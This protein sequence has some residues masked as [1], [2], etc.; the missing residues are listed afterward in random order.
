MNVIGRFLVIIFVIF[1]PHTKCGSK[2]NFFFEYSNIFKPLN[3]LNVSAGPGI[4]PYIQKSMNGFRNSV[5]IAAAPRSTF[6]NR[7]EITS[8][9]KDIHE[10]ATPFK[11]AVCYCVSCR[12]EHRLYV[13]Y[14][15]IFTHERLEEPRQVNT[16][17]I[18]QMRFLCVW[19]VLM[20]P[21]KCFMCFSK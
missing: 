15:H 8:G 16:N 4:I 13:A 10:L 5:R 20:L 11:D 2:T 17:K 6:T 7:S 21:L 12:I 9:S 18:E 14:E 1:T 3:E 19:P